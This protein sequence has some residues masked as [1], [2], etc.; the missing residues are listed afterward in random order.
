MNLLT[1]IQTACDDPTLLNCLEDVHE[2]KNLSL[3]Q[4]E[5]LLTAITTR[6][7][8]LHPRGEFNLNTHLSI[9]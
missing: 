8:Q 6:F 5:E 7:E 9:I 4:K 1:T 2:D 3:E